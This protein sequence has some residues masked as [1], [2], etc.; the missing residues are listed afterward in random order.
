MTAKE[1]DSL[2]ADQRE[3]IRFAFAHDPMLMSASER[4]DV[5]AMLR[6][7]AWREHR[8]QDFQR[9]MED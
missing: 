8:A 9:D 5:S 1:W 4:R 3:E 7:E 2:T 6:L